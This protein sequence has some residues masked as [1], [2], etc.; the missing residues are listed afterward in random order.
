MMDKTVTSEEL[1]PD[2]PIRVTTRYSLVC[3][4]CDRLRRLLAQAQH[5]VLT[6]TTECDALIKRVRELESGHQSG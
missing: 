2:G 6:L 4:D 3:P 1:W 5:R